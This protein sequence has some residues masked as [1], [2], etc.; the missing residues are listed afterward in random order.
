MAVTTPLTVWLPVTINSIDDDAPIISCCPIP[1]LF[2]ATG[3]L[4]I[5]IDPTYFALR[6]SS[7]IWTFIITVLFSWPGILI[8]VIFVAGS[9]ES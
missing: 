1:L 9:S 7:G 8:I 4:L 3:I 5:S 6:V 2:A